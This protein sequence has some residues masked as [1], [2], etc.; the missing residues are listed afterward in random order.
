MLERAVRGEVAMDLVL[1]GG[2]RVS[3]ALAGVEQAMHT[4]ALALA[5]MLHRSVTIAHGSQDRWANPDES[6]LLLGAL[7]D[8]GAGPRR[9]VIDGAG[10]D[11]AEAS[12]SQIAALAADLA[13]RLQP[14]DLPPVLL[15]IEE[16]G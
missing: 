3:L 16:M 13:A 14:R 12:D 1:A 7:P 11:L 9:V 6:L 4:P 10:H 5:T 15:A 2:E 8:A